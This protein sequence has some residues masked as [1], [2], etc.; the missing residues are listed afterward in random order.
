MYS[1]KRANAYA[2][3]GLETGVMSASPHQL[4]VMLF[5]GAQ[6]ALKKAQWAVEQNDV[7]TKCAALS[8]AI[9]II[10]EGLRASL[11]KDQGGEIADNLDNLYEYM[12]RTLTRA[13]ARNDL[14]AI[15]HVDALLADISSA[16]KDIATEPQSAVSA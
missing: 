10:E 9:R 7:Q 13:N 8:K 5:D 12:S 15:R 1:R 14:E 4:I 11:D 6:A 3:I 16:W 2:N